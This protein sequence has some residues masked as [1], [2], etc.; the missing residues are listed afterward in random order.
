M[1]TLNI[2]L[3]LL[4]AIG[5]RLLGRKLL[6]LLMPPGRLKPVLLAWAGAAAGSL[7]EK[8]LWPGGPALGW[9][10]P[11]GAAVGA[12]LLLVAMGLVP[13]FK[14]LMGRIQPR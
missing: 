14:V 4:I 10:H 11:A 3:L 9:L 7:L 12:L 13:F 2:F 8:A 6:P 1:D 5:V